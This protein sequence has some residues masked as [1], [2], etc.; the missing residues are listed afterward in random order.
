MAT[1]YGVIGWE[2]VNSKDSDKQAHKQKTER[3][4]NAGVLTL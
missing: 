4:V 2:R 3:F 1:Q